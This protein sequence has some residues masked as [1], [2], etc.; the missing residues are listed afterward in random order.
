MVTHLRERRRLTVITNGIL[1]VTAL[2]GVPGITV[3]MPGGFLYRDSASLVGRANQSFIEKYHFN[4]GFFGA[5]GF[6]LKE[7]LSDINSAEVAIKSDL[8]SSAKHVIAV[9]DSSKWGVRR[10]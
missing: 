6:T 9:V 10:L 2:M 5:K 7:G 3:L 1:T 4:K 8:V